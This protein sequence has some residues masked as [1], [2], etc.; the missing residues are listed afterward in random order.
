M[1]RLAAGSGL[2]FSGSDWDFRTLSRTYDA[3]EAIAVEDL[4]LD[5]YPVQMEVISSE[6]MLDAYSSV[7]MPLMYRH[8]SFGKHFLYQQLLYRKGGRGLAYELVINS[9]PCIVYLMEENTMAL[10]ALVTAH[11]ALGHNHFFK[12]NHLF[13]QWTDAGSILSY[14]DFAKRYIARCEERHGL[15]EVEAVLDA[16]HAL[17]EQGVFRYRRPPKPSSQKRKESARERLEYEEQSYN[18]LWRTLPGPKEGR[19]DKDDKADDNAAER[20][21]TLNLPEENLLY[22]LEKNSP[23]LE[24]WQREIVRI[25][26]VIAQYFYPQRQTQVMNEG[27]ATFVHY[28]LMN[29]LFDR[30]VI[31]EGS[32]L[33]ILKNHS[34]VIF[35]PGFDDPRFSG[36]NPYAL[37]LDMM[38]DIKRIATGPTPED[39]DWFPDIAGGGDWRRILLDAWADHRDESFIRQYLSPALI[40][41]WRFFLLNDAAGQPQYEVASIHDERGYEA[42]RAAL[43]DSYDIGATRPDIQVADVDLLGDRHLR[44][45][46]KVRN[47]IL[48]DEAACDATLRHVR[49]LWGY[50]VSL[51]GVDEETGSLLYERAANRTAD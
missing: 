44:L 7:G 37:G 33:E 8:W 11:A 38:Q 40:R 16:A 23:V 2:L 41:K 24:P 49:R 21:E 31:D 14:L 36:I 42:I 9:N 43:A 22:F 20:R 50:D 10:Q 39:R 15:A 27:C 1:T 29:T 25:V 45:R 35:Q 46:H 34:N 19:E 18:D 4:R 6:Q 13:R 28:T 47:G 48:L 12:N 32:M 26:R 5:T 30:G 51:A 17:M 3:I